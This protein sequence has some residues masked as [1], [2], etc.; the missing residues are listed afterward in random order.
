MRLSSLH[1]SP[2]AL[3]ATAL[4]L[5]ITACSSGPR[6]DA[7]SAES[8]TQSLNAYATQGGGKANA[9]TRKQWVA[10]V[11]K[12]YVKDGQFKKTLP[13]L[14]PVDVFKAAKFSDLDLLLPKVI[15][16]ASPPSETDK[17]PQGVEPMVPEEDDALVRVW[18]NRFILK[19]LED[20]EVLLKARK[21][22][23]RYKDL[24]T[25][26]QMEFLD[27]QFIPPQP[28]MPLGQ[29][30]ATFA[31][32][33]RNDTG[34]NLYKPSFSLKITVP[35]EELP[36]LDTVLVYDPSK[37][38]KSVQKKQP[39]LPGTTETVLLTCCNSFSDP[40]TNSRL[41]RLPPNARIDMNLVGIDDYA[42]KN[43]IQ[44]S[45]YTA[46]DHATYTAAVACMEEIRA[47]VDGWRQSNQSEAC[48]RK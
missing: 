14:P 36:V 41:R 35:G 19:Q 4:L 18:R 8:L 3:L 6:V 7:Q 10:E 28:G 23:S 32:K 9:A 46:Q 21:E 42:G 15:A 16:K 13:Q 1:P 12:L 22:V 45:M 30:V 25:V 39:I 40:L 47:D 2:K 48:D 44:N 38:A 5:S 33:F 31:V 26:D 11:L 20:T 24:F 37:G 29:D 34:F 17:L 27:A 43:L